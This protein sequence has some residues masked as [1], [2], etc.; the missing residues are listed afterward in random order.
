MWRAVLVLVCFWPARW[1]GTSSTFWR[2]Y[3]FA[4]GKVTFFFLFKE[5]R[6]WN[7]WA[8][9]WNSA[10]ITVLLPE[11]WAGGGTWLVAAASRTREMDVNLLAES[12]RRPLSPNVYTPVCTISPPPTPSLFDHVRLQLDRNPFM[13]SLTFGP[14][15][16]AASTNW[17]QLDGELHHWFLFFGYRLK[18]KQSERSC[19]NL[20]APSSFFFFICILS[21]FLE[22]VCRPPKGP[23]HG[24]VCERRG[25]KKACLQ[26]W[27][28]GF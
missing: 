12:T 3:S 21:I 15:L 13:F 20:S 17:G 2:F 4:L 22:N 8:R 10:F 27:V 16:A 24:N 26:L 11:P 23:S 14:Q 5:K 18:L 1:I 19:W 7:A 28:S 6:T 25:E 9:R